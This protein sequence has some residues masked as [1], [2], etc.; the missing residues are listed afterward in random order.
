MFKV[1]IHACFLIAINKFLFTISGLSAGKFTREYSRMNVLIDKISLIHTI[2][3]KAHFNSIMYW[4]HILRD[5]SKEKFVA[6][7]KYYWKAKYNTNLI[8]KLDE[9]CN[10]F[11]RVG[12]SHNLY[13]KFEF[14]VSKL[15]EVGWEQLFLIF[16]LFFEGGYKE[17]YQNLRVD[18][19]ELAIDFKNIEFNSVCAVDIK[20]KEFGDKYQDDNSLYYGS[21]SSNKVIAFY[22]KANQLKKVEEVL[23]DHELLRVEFRI[24]KSKLKL[25]ELIGIK[26]PFSSFDIFDINKSHILDNRPSWIKFKSLVLEEG[27]HPQIAYLSFS[28]DEREALTMPIKLCVYKWWEPTKAWELAK[29]RINELAPV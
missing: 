19:I 14:N 23:L 21:K 9:K 28:A 16:D 11:I 24:K 26:N 2:E 27:L 18:Y 1:L 8:I 7:E 13:V 3:T 5:E 22:D 12:T 15:S 10:L 29:L 6:N 20:I 4:I 25:Y 17:A